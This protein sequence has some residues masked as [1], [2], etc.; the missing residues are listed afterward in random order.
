MCF[1]F[2]FWG[3]KHKKE[4]NFIPDPKSFIKVFRQLPFFNFDFEIV[5]YVDLQSA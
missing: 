5:I 2:V 4:I 3:C 1:I